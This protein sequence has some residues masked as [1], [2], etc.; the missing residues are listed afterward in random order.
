[1]SRFWSPAVHDLEP[2]VPGEQPKGQVFIKLNTNE[3]PWGPSPLALAAMSAATGDELRLYPDPLAGDLRAAIGAHYGL[4]ADHVFAG[5]GSDEVLGH[6][7]AAFFRDKGPVLFAD[8]TYSF[9]PV[10]CDLHGISYRRIATDA[11]FRIHTADY[12]GGCGGI[13][14]ANPNAPTGIALP[15]T[16]V[17]RLL[18]A[19]PDVVVLVDE[20]YVDFGAESAAGL[21]AKYDN[22]LVVQTFSKS[23]SLAGLR[24]GFALGQPHLIEGLVRIKDSFN[25]YPL[26]RTALA[27]ATASWN[28]RAWFDETRA[29]VMADRDAMAAGLV[30]LGFQVLPS[31]TNFVF[32][33]HPGRDAADLLAALRARGI[34]VRHFKSEKIR[35][36]LRISVGTPEECQAL[37]AAM[38]AILAE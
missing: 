37:V 12:A 6:A 27:G 38:A 28:D 26:G 33:S 8:V 11:D 34:L 4:S 20:A 16:E 29:R 21:V 15:L 24:V 5:N 31:Q 23:R 22:L 14:L 19:H 25:S 32:A 18:Q 13:I 10:W 2:Y 1:M 30:R 3:N 17:E 36:W 7:F 9:Y 35:N